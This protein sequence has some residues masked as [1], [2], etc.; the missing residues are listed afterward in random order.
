MTNCWLMLFGPS[1]SFHLPRRHR[2]L[3]SGGSTPTASSQ[4]RCKGECRKPATTR[5]GQTISVEVNLAAH[6]DIELVIENGL[7]RVPDVVF[8]WIPPWLYIRTWYA[9]AYDAVTR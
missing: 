4:F 9:R 8:I 5:D 3:S 7:F 1:W 2:L 6:D